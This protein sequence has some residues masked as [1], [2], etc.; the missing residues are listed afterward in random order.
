ME[1]GTVP[2]SM[3]F[4]FLDSKLLVLGVLLNKRGGEN[5]KASRKNE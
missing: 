5:A 2:F 1:K 3:G 4:L